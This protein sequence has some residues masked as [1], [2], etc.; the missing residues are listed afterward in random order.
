[1]LRVPILE[2]CG[3]RVPRTIEEA[4]AWYKKIAFLVHPDK[5]G[6]K[7]QFQDLENEYAQCKDHFGVNIKQYNSTSKDEM[8]DRFTQELATKMKRFGQIMHG[9]DEKS[10]SELDE[11]WYNVL[12]TLQVNKLN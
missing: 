5:G 6:T 1:M 4:K 9:R 2:K 10:I 8:F 7:K 12:Q 11:V 3:G